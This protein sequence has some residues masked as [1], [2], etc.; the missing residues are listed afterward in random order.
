M[1]VYLDPRAPFAKGIPRSDTLFG[2]VA[3]AIRLLYGE[4]TLTDLLDEFD[5]AIK[6]R[7]APPFVLSSLFPYFEDLEGRLLFLP[8]PLSPMTFASEIKGVSDYRRRKAVQQITHVSQ[9]VFNQMACGTLAVQ[10]ILLE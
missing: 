9:A 4:E 2:G 3:W 5:K 10:Q 7:Q 1:I 8:A 6:A